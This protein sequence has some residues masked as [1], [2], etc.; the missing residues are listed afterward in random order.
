MF[1]DAYKSNNSERV[2]GHVTAQQFRQALRVKL[3]LQLLAPQESLLLKKFKHPDY[4]QL[5]N[6]RA[7]ANTV[8]PPANKHTGTLWSL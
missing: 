1:D 6:Y 2:V 5:I 8:V 4:P 3:G 7:F